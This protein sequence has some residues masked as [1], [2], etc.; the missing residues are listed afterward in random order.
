MGRAA[1]NEIRPYPRAREV[2]VT[3]EKAICARVDRYSSGR[4]R[5]YRVSSLSVFR[6][7]A[8]S[9]SPRGFTTGVLALKALSFLMG[10]PINYEL[11][12]RPRYHL[13]QINWAPRNIKYS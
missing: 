10:I 8:A 3:L 12:E 11:R 13:P 9:W 7:A 1:F 4:G 6:K 2:L 5:L